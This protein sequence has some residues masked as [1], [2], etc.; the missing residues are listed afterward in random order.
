MSKGVWQNTIV[1]DEGQVQPY[2]SV[3]FRYVNGDLADLF[4]DVA[5]TPL[6]GNPQLTD[7]EGF[8]RVYLTP[9]VRH[10]IT[11][12]KNG[13][14]KTWLDVVV[15]IE[16]SADFGESINAATEKTT[17]VDADI[18][19]LVDSAASFV[20]KKLSWANIKATLKTYFDTIYASIY[21]RSGV[22]G[23][24]PSN[25]AD[26]TNDL[27]FSAGRRND[28]TNVY[29]IISGAMTKR[30]DAAW[31]AGTGNGMLASGATAWGATDYHYFLLGKSTDPNAHD[32]VQDSSVTCANGMADAN[33]IAAGFDIFKRVYSERTA[34][35]A[36]RLITAREIAT[37]LLEVLLMTPIFEIFKDWSG[38]DDG[39][40]TGTLAGG[41]PGGI[42]VNA[43]LAG[44]FQDGSPG[45]T[46]G[47]MITALDQ[48]D[49]ALS[50]TLSS[51]LAEIRLLASADSSINETCL[52]KV[53][54][55]TSRTFRYRGSGTTVD[56]TAAFMCQGWEDSRV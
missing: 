21:V 42:Q 46:S 10:D 26:A 40:Q 27:T 20:L 32:Y 2:A 23:N 53:R 7:G 41:V 3:T 38:V 1:N 33:I 50:L 5:G 43:I 49:T 28:S 54:T 6:P 13:Q 11:A 8:I 56:H 14:T 17:P 44:I 48:T 24:V 45:A 25:A 29:T 47:L 34:G 19:A 35:A 37:G 31:S 16:F 51:F 52:K 36:H 22:Y 12:V 15:S 18:F 55:S 4:S 30:S 9:G 39:A